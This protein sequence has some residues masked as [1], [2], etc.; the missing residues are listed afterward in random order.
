MKNKKI[1][2][3]KNISVKF[4]NFFAVNDV[5]FEVC[6]GEIFGFL[7]A[8]GAGKTTTIRVLCG[9]LP[10]SSGVVIVDDVLFI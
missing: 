7:G 10:A 5:S 2:V 4:D 6:R 3:G 1:V 9:L 8:N